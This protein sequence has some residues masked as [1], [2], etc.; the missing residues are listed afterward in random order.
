MIFPSEYLTVDFEEVKTAP[1]ECKEKCFPMMSS[2]YLHNIKAPQWDSPVKVN[3]GFK[4]VCVNS[5]YQPTLSRKAGRH[6][7]SHMYN[8]ILRTKV[9]K[10]NNNRQPTSRTPF[11]WQRLH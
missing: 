4:Y 1:T 2:A 7:L 3:V 9:R 11:S 6:Q 10:L 5:L 8:N